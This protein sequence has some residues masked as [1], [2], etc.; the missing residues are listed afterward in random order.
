MGNLNFHTWELL[1]AYVDGALDETGAAVVERAVQDH[2]E[3]EAALASLRRQKGALDDW[4]SSIDRRPLPAGVRAML[5]RA[6]DEAGAVGE[7]E[8]CREG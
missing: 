5:D 7:R 8:C 3:L 2:P 1:S 4:A 6:R